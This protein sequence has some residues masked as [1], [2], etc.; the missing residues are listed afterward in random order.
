LLGFQTLLK[1]VKR[2]G[3]IMVG[4][5]NTYGRILTDVRRFI[6]RLSG[7][8]FKFFDARLRDKNVSDVRKHTWF[9]DQ[10]QHPHESKH[11][12]GEVLDWFDQCGVE[13]VSSIPKFKAFESFSPEEEL[14][15]INPR[16]SRLDHFWV[17]SGMVFSGRKEGGFF[18]TIG[19]KV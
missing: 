16:G 9:R 10:Y 17:Q 14:F 13:F 1:L 3:F 4:L 12:F 15:K 11:T 19:R 2:G 7:N 18:V 6:F 5:Y 8:R